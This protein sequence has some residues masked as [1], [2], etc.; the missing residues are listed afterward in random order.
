[1]QLQHFQQLFTAGTSQAFQD[2]SAC[3]NHRLCIASK[4]PRNLT[5]SSTSNLHDLLNNQFRTIPQSS[6][7]RRITASLPSPV[8][9]L[10]ESRCTPDDSGERDLPSTALLLSFA[11]QPA[12]GLLKAFQKQTRT[13]YHMPY[14]WQNAVPKVYQAQVRPLRRLDKCYKPL[15]VQVTVSNRGVADSKA[16]K[17]KNLAGHGIY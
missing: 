11:I 6:D 13:T 5:T 9:D 3:T 14:R 12:P 1:M 16:E 15:L 8:W 7:Q 4:L 17:K 10:H 2:S